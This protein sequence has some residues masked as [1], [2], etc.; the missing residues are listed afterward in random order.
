MRG[1]IPL[2]ERARVSFQSDVAGEVVERPV[3]RRDK[4]LWSEATVADG[5]AGA[6]QPAMT[7]CDVSVTAL[8][9]F[10]SLPR[11]SRM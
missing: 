4:P 2:A 6:N 9:R 1:I 10:T 5:E 7:Q 3:G 8:S 11:L